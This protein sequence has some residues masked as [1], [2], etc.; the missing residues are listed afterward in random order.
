MLRYIV[1]RVGQLVPI[2]IGISVVTFL[3][4]HLVPGDP[5][6]IFAGDKPLTEAR[7]AEIRHELG[8]D[9]PIWIQYWGYA[10]HAVRGDLGRGLRSQR[11]VLDSILEVLPGTAQ[12]TLAA[13]AL[14]TAVGVTLGTVAAL[15][16]GSWVD[17][18]AMAL[19]I[20]GVSMPVFYSSLLLILLFSFTLGWFPATGQGGLER[21]VMP[22]TALGLISSAVLARLVRSGMLGVLHQE[23]IVTARAKGLAPQ[24]V[25]LRHAL[26]NALIPTITMLGLQLGALLG[27]AVVTETIFSRPGVGRLAVDAILS[28]DFPL[29]QGTVLVAAV[30]YV[31]V[32]LLVDIS[33]AAVDPRIHYG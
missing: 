25:V 2:L 14:A 16:H 22:A 29:V 21:L 4:L 18:A 27:G 9:R 30:A 7:A 13:L 10:T 23:Y 15:A 5:V 19:A 28:R 8:L 17:T 12:L 24:A 1:Q 26:K 6:L 32:N 20:L 3:M 31:L 33:Y 11:P